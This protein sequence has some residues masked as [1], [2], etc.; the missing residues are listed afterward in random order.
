MIYQVLI[1]DDEEIV[2]RGLA[3]FVKWKEHGF[4]VAGMAYSVDE[5]LKLMEQ[6]H[7]DV[8][9]MD[10]QMPEKTGLDLLKL[11]HKTSPE[12]KTVIL[13]GHS[14]FSY[15]QEAIR[16]GA[17]DY[18]TKPVNLG[19]VEEVLERLR[20]GFLQREKESRI[21]SDRVE[22]LLLS[23][24][25][26][27][28]PLTPERYHFPVVGKWYGC[29][30]SLGDK[31]LEEQEISGKMQELRAHVLSLVPKAILL[32]AEAYSL[33]AILPCES[34]EELENFVSMIEPF[35][36]RTGEWE[37]GMSKCK[38]GILKLKEAWQEASMALHYQRASGKK[39]V[40][41]YHNIEALFAE[42]RMETK[43]L[44]AEL[45]CRLSNPETRNGMISWL[46]EALSELQGSG[47][48]KTEFQTVCIRCLIELNSYL[49]GLNMK[50]PELHSSLNKT[51]R[52]ILLSDDNEHML[53][54][55][56]SYL[57][58]ILDLLSKGDTQQISKGAIREIQIFIRGHYSENITLNM[59]AEQ[60]YLHP[61]Y[62]SRLFKEKTGKNFSE[63]LT[64]VRLEKAEELLRNSD[65]KIIEICAMT[66]YDNPRYFSKMF[67]QHTGMTP[68][69]FRDCR[70]EQKEN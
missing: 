2:C 6:L 8:V 26:G 27:Y 56:I 69:E 22:G 35:F 34:K 25:R 63:Y 65:Y 51:L 68:R 61:N 67:K 54:F 47:L 14:D 11:M 43:D 46:M 16:Y 30:L 36:C 4:E 66:G 1:V 13:S 60:F 39:N 44:T 15:A 37:C 17:V 50:E 48:S 23:M 29:F 20:E 28:M 62:L 3:Q 40:I 57:K 49:K 19:M 24:A 18:L 5:A 10:I 55:M 53:S 7:I 12:I 45:L 38:E 33:F 70:G 31:T 21:R 41:F 59:L 52:E 9:F 58:W 42:D 64:E 32:N